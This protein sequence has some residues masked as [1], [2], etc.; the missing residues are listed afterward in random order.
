MLKG[1][2]FCFLLILFLF[3]I[4]ACEK[5]VDIP[6]VKNEKTLIERAKKDFLSGN[7]TTLSDMPV[8]FLQ[9]ADPKFKNP[10]QR[11]FDNCRINKSRMFD[12]FKSSEG[13]EWWAVEFDFV[14]IDKETNT[15]KHGV[16][17]LTYSTGHYRESVGGGDAIEKEIGLASVF[18][19]TSDRK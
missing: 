16:A 6:E 12:Y 3:S 1:K 17:I 19:G 14:G 5:A 18:T 8:Q 15:E 11:Q 4:T 7:W 9:M 13:E 10:L 2:L